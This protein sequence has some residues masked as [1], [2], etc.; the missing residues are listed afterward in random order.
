MTMNGKIVFFAL[1]FA[2]VISYMPLQAQKVVIQVWD[3][4]DSTSVIGALVSCGRQTAASDVNGKVAFS[5]SEFPVSLTVKAPGFLPYQANLASPDSRIMIYLSSS[6]RQLDEV[7]ISSSRYEQNIAKVPVSIQLIKP[8]LIENKNTVN[9]ETII[10]QVPGVSVT[11]GQVSMRGQSGFSYG[12]GSR[13]MLLVDDMPLLAGDASDIKFN[14]LPVENIEQV[15][16]MKGAGSAMYGSSALNGVINVRTGYAKEK[17]ETRLTLYSGVYDNPMRGALKWWGNANPTYSGLNFYHARKI[18][19]FE[20]VAGANY[21]NDEGYRMGEKEQRIRF[22]LNT[23]Y[24]FQK[25]KGLSAGINGNAQRTGGALF[26]LWQ[27]KDSGALKPLP[28]TLSNY[29]TYRVNVDPWVNWYSGSRTKHTLRSR[30]YVTNNLNDTK[31]DSRSDVLYSEYVLRHTFLQDWVLN[32]GL[33]YISNRIKSDSLF[34]NHTGSNAAFFFQL[35]KDIGPLSLSLGARAEYFELNGIANRPSI[36]LPSIGRNIP[37]LNTPF[38]PVGRLGITWQVFESSY[39]R[40]SI[41]Q[42]YRYPSVA[43]KFVSTSVGGLTVFPNRDLLPEYGYNAEL[44]IKQGFKIGKLYGY[45]DAAFFYSEFQNTIEYIFDYYVPDSIKKPNISQKLRYAGFT[46][47]NV[48]KT[49]IRGIDVSLN[50]G[51]KIRQVGMTAMLGYT[52]T[53]GRSLNADSSYVLTGTDSSQVL[54]YRNRHMFKGDLQLDYGRFSLGWS[55]RYMS[56]M[57]NIDIAFQQDI[58]GALIPGVQS[59]LFIVPG[60]A[61]YRNIHNTGKTICDA[62]MAFEMKP[63]SKISLIVNNVFNIEMMGRPAD[64]QPMRTFVIQYA[65][66]F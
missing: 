53:D 49:M 18:K 23:R 32:A 26:I 34:G 55:V 44:G 52:L 28:G 25:I 36:E 24:N 58:L 1:L 21:F 66:R 8:A 9:L 15:E 14:F 38:M 51:G 12:A 30:Y 3:A 22:N 65:M 20:I 60:L 62:R 47:R 40:G 59:N 6:P 10:D 13:V 7:I 11:D 37:K 33:V 19:Q 5:I 48:G 4:G 35:N 17:P 64:I 45:A 50:A 43:E 39:L 41:G 2:L 61:E 56:Y 63:G 46:S 16:V 42:G 29:I 54:K 57:Q 31:Q 27:N